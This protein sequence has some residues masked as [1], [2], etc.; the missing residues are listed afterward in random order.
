MNMRAQ[1]IRKLFN[2]IGGYKPLA[3]MDKYFFR[4]ELEKR[5]DI[6]SVKY[7]REDIQNNK[8][9]FNPQRRTIMEKSVEIAENI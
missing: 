4:N 2:N 7:K 3:F 1:Y 6:I 9:L 5:L 8:Q